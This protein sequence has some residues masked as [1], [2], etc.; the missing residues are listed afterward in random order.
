MTLCPALR[1]MAAAELLRG[2]ERGTLGFNT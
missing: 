1:M 2:S